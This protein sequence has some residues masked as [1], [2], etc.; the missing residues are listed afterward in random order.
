[1]ST[2]TAASALDPPTPG[3]RDILLLCRDD[4]K[5]IHGAAVRVYGNG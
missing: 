4:A 1:M 5:L 3:D 2:W